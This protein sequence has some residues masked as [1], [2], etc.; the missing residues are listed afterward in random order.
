MVI[1]IQHNTSYI[2]QKLKKKHYNFSNRKLW[3]PLCNPMR[4]KIV[5][6]EF[7]D[8]IKFSEV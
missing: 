7:D 1:V 4:I 2:N 6:H 5:P 8:I 3:K